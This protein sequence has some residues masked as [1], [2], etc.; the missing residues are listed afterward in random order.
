[1]RGRTGYVLVALA[2]ACSWPAAALSAAARHAPRATKASF[3]GH[4]QVTEVEYHLMLSRGVV[5]AGDVDLQQIDA[6]MDP[7]DLRLRRS[8]SGST[9]YGRLLGSGQRWSGIV[10]LSPGVYK[11]WCSLPEHERLGMHAVLRVVR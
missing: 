10:H 2:L 6:G 9:V 5:K 7:H 8:G 4:L 1:M 11:L 3:P